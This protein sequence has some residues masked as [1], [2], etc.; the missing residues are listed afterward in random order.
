M[1]PCGVCEE[2]FLLTFLTENLSSARS[3]GA[4]TTQYTRVFISEQ[5]LDYARRYEMKDM[6]KA[7]AQQLL[8]ICRTVQMAPNR[9]HMEAQA[10]IQRFKGKQLMSVQAV[11]VR[12]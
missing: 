3:R 7:K 10:V 2:Q 4:Y 5:N 12:G 9:G 6:C 8:C 1:V 11:A